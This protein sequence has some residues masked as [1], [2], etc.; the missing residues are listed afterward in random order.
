MDSIQIVAGARAIAVTHPGRSEHLRWQ[1]ARVD[2]TAIAFCIPRPPMGHAPASAT[3]MEVDVP[4]IP[5]VGV[6]RRR[7]GPEGDLACRVIRSKHTRPA[8]HSEQ[9]HSVTSVGGAESCSVTVPQ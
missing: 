8:R 1:Q 4:A 2:A 3:A 6:G 7:I 5:R 9:L